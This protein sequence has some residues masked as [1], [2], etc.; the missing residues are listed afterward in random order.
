M[1]VKKQSIHF[2]A[3]TNLLEFVDKKVGKLQTFHDKIID[4]EVFLRLDQE[5]A[6]VKEKVAEL[7]IS[8]PGKILFSKEQ[9]KSFEESVD[10]A[11]ESMRRQLLKQKEK[12][13]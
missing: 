7:K 13:S 9:S 8:V 2:D 6:K 10:K 4:A 5:G 12:A 3:D 11:V 1:E